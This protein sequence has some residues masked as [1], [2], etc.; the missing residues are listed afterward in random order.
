MTR[1]TI[2]PAQ[3]KATQSDGWW[4]LG[5]LLPNLSVDGPK[6]ADTGLVDRFGN[7]IVR[8]QPPIGFG[9]DAGW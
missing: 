4:D 2:R 8:I 5:P 6:E 3:P 9:R 1:Y 7:R